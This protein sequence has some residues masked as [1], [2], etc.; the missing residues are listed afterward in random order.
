LVIGEFRVAVSRKLLAVTAPLLMLSDGNET[1]VNLPAQ[2]AAKMSTDI[3][4][5]FVRV[6][7][8]I[9]QYFCFFFRCH[10]M[11]IG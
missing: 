2:E 11:R 4:Q 3:L 10:S 5:S 9:A 7:F 6:S 8:L 1:V